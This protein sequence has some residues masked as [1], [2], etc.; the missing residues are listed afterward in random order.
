MEVN[1]AGFSCGCAGDEDPVGG[2]VQELPRIVQLPLLPPKKNRKK[3]ALCKKGP[4]LLFPMINYVNFYR[5]IPC[6]SGVVDP[7]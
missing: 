2:L 5:E 1:S 3:L 6:K 4:V 7:E